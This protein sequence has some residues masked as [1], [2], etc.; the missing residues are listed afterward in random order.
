MKIK[1]NLSSSKLESISKA[2]IK[3]S[4]KREK[5]YKASNPAES[6]MMDDMDELFT[7]F[8]SDITG[9][10]NETLIGATHER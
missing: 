6:E 10:V 5:P 8:M 7:E 9:D 4:Q 3:A 1:T 2:L